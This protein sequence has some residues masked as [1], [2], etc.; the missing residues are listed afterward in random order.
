MNDAFHMAASGMS[1]VARMLDVAARNAVNANTPGYVSRELATHSFLKELDIQLGREGSYLETTETSKF[2]QG[3]IVPSDDPT[4]VALDGPGFL[5]L[6]GPNGP[7]YTRDGKLRVSPEGLLSTHAGMAVMGESGPIRI[8]LQAGSG[9]RIDDQGRVY[10][11][12]LEVG[13]LKLVEFADRNLLERVGE[14]MFRAPDR[15]APVAAQETRIVA[16]SLEFPAEKSVISMVRMIEASKAFEAQQRV[17]RT[18]S[19]TY[20]NLIRNQ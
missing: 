20:E 18:L 11:G 5:V 10:Q 14:T 16:E 17:I 1:A 2:T 8:D 4:H 13:R 15:A 3:T 7:L 6:R 19:R 9:V 12:Q